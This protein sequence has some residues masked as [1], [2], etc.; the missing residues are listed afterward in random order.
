MPEVN[1]GPLEQIPPGEGR[2]FEID[3]RKVAVFHLRGGTVRAV[4]AECPHRVGPLAD[5][6]TGDGTV[7]CPFHAWKF[8]LTT[9]KALTAV[10]GDACLDVYPTCLTADGSITLT[11][12]PLLRNSEPECTASF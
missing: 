10:S 9:G 3:G 4:Q 5:G 1:L 2:E 6:I 8:D 7:V 12:L 11:L